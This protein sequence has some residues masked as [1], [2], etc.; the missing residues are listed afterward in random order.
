MNHFPLW[1]F[2]EKGQNITPDKLRLGQAKDIF[3]ACDE[4]LI[5][6]IE[7]LQA[8]TIVAVGKYA[9]KMA[10][11]AMSASKNKNIKI[12]VI[13]HPSPANPIANKDKGTLWKR[14]VKDIL[15]G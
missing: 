4:H 13:P 10:K 1:M 8:D 7:I 2:N 14:I 5:S 9:E 3:D 6:V 12:K 11:K 15:T